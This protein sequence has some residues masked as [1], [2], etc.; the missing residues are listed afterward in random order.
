[1]RKLHLLLSMLLMAI[2]SFAQQKIITGTVIN[3]SSKE[4]LQGVSVVTKN[5]SVLTDSSGKFSIPA[6]VGET[7]TLSFRRD[8]C[9]EF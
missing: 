9:T 3:N 5:H 2:F 8:E 4:P 1:M 7:V 6:T